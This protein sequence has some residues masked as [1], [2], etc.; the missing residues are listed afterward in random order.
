MISILF[1]LFLFDFILGAEFKYKEK[2][3]LERLHLVTM[4]T[5]V[6][7]KSAN[8]PLEKSANEPLEKS[9]DK[10]LGKS[11]DNPWPQAVDKPLGKS[12]A[13]ALAVA[14]ALGIFVKEPKEG[15]SG[16]STKA[17]NKRAGEER[18]VVIDKKRSCAGK[19][20][21]QLVRENQSPDRSCAGKSLQQLIREGQS[22]VVL[23]MTVYF[24]ICNGE[25][26]A[27]TCGH[28]YAKNKPNESMK[29]A[30]RKK[31]QFVRKGPYWDDSFDSYPK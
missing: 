8:E 5:S 29:A 6:M 31:R 24:P 7:E 22:P 13:K 12:V 26:E 11:Q 25:C 17:C 28:C 16:M 21:Q 9:T 1:I 2:K 10:T 30:R 15:A 23:E 3:V 18:D 4:A 19:S 27:A 20:P 14:Y